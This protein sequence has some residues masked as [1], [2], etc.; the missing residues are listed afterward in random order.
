MERI[1]RVHRRSPK[2]VRSLP[3]ERCCNFPFRAARSTLA[4]RGCSYS[5]VGNAGTLCA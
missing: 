4:L 1:R 2:H 5:R 3:V